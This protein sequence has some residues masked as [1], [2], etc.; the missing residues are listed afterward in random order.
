M[1]PIP[2]PLGPA[3]AGPAPGPAPLDRPDKPTPSE[4]PRRATSVLELLS[5]AIENWPRTLRLVVILLTVGAC[6]AAIL[7]VLQLNGHLWAS[8]L[9]VGTSVVAGVL[10]LS[11]RG[12][13]KDPPEDP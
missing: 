4:P 11:R 12:G 2:A 10:S 6:L 13:G 8:A 3:S 1:S 9:A 7:Y 5:D